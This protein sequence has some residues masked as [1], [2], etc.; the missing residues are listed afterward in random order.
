MNC[1]IYLENHCA[2]TFCSPSVGESSWNSSG[3][4]RLQYPF[5]NSGPRGAHFHVAITVI[6][7]RCCAKYTLFLPVNPRAFFPSCDSTDRCCYRHAAPLNPRRA[8]IAEHATKYHYITTHQVWQPTTS[9][10]SIS[11]N[12]TFSSKSQLKISN[13]RLRKT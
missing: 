6:P 3:I 2:V 10:N 13:I 8:Y 1:R 12:F 11:K 5:G 9:G 4:K 7:S